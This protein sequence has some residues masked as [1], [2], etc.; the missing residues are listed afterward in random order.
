MNNIFALAKNNNSYLLFKT[1]TN[2]I[3]KNVNWKNNCL[4]WKKQTLLYKSIDPEKKRSTEEDQK[5][6]KE[7][8]VKYY[9]ELVSSDDEVTLIY[10]YNS[11]S[12]KPVYSLKKI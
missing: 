5:K 7:V 11:G 12:D 9:D 2:K 6:R 10:K 3:L 4:K 1:N 8:E